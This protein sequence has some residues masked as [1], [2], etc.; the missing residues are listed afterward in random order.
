[1]RQTFGKSRV[2]IM[3]DDTCHNDTQHNDT[4]DKGLNCDTQHNDTHHKV[5]QHNSVVN[6]ECCYNK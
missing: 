2:S 6:A 4:Y 5:T 3:P 1:M